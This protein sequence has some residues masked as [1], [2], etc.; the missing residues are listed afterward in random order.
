M[1]LRS[2]WDQS[3]VLKLAE[4]NLDELLGGSGGLSK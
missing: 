2:A 1:R 3:E 4:L